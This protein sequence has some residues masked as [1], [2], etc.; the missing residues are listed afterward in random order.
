MSNIQYP[1]SA[2]P[3]VS[4][5]IPAYNAAQY[6]DD[7][8]ESV[9]AQSYSDIEIIFIDDG[10][11]DETLELARRH[12]NEDDRIKLVTQKNQ[13]AGVARNAGI[14][15]A[16][17]KYLYF[18][19]ADDHLESYAI[20][21]AVQRAEGTN[22]DIVIFR[23]MAFDNAQG[24]EYEL[25]H[26]LRVTDMEAV[27]S[28]W[29][30]RESLFQFCVGW[31]WD[32]LFRASFVE[33]HKLRFQSLRTTN[34]AFFVFVSLALAQRISFV[35]YFGARHRV[36]NADSLEGSRK[37]SYG[38]ALVAAQAI[39]DRLNQEGCLE[40][41]KASYFNWVFDFSIWNY[42]TLDDNVARIGFL[43]LFEETV[44]PL[45]SNGCDISLLREERYRKLYR[46]L[47]RSRIEL[48]DSTLEALVDAEELTSRLQ[49]MENELSMKRIETERMSERIAALSERNSSLE[50]E[51]NG[52]LNSK[53]YKLGNAIATP[54]RAIWKLLRLR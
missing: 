8:L 7:C 2:T 33:R 28:G 3:M 18:F 22:S 27:V 47:G 36:H 11:T 9:R 5:V 23:S 32:K 15:L 12:A 41:F 25:E 45:I 31:T 26:A 42:S 30:F 50:G 1:S 35:D 29:D 52:V 24:Y 44:A 21:R 43:Q 49:N 38:N 53:A 37:K 34:D 4:V 48:M 19:D 6:V 16:K 39:G 14:A 13:Y 20:E 46:L 51:L 17:G 10:S 40:D 54:Y